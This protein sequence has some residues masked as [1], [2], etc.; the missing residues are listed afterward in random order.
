MKKQAEKRKIETSI[1]TERVEKK[2]RLEEEGQDKSK[3]VT[4]AYNVN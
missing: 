3:F 4:K 2:K 1:I